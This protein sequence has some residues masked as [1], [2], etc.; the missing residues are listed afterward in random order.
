MEKKVFLQ[1]YEICY[2]LTYKKVKRINLRINL[3]GEVMVSAPRG[4]KAE[5]IEK[6]LN[7]N[8]DWILK[9][10]KLMAE[11]RDEIKTQDELDIAVIYKIF[12]KVY[13]DFSSVLKKA[14]TLKIKSLKS[15][16]GNC[17]RKTY[18]VTVNSQLLRTDEKLIEYVIY[19]EFV[20]FFHGGH[21]KDFYHALMTY[22][23]DY[24]KCR[25]RLN[26]IRIN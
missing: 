8:D 5:F 11:K 1:G 22:F 2:T 13:D 7:K 12:D 19:H 3:N 25:K 6:F 23:P 9:N 4:T 15:M 18:C 20:H 10:V 14:P 21:Q 16:W 26:K 24:E 17:N